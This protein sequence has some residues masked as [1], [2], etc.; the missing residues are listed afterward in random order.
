MLVEAWID[1]TMMQGTSC[2]TSRQ[3]SHLELNMSRVVMNGSPTCY[4][5][6]IVNPQMVTGYLSLTLVFLFFG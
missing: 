3:L 4:A 1:Q 5:K 6:H 2:F